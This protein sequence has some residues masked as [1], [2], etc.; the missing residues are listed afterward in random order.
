MALRT[1]NSTVRQALLEND[2]FILAHLIKF[3][4]PQPQEGTPTGVNDF[5]YLTDA[6][7]PLTLDSIEYRPARVMSIGTVKENVEAKA[8]QLSIKLG[9]SDIGTTVTET[10]DVVSGQYIDLK[11]DALKAGFKVGDV[12]KQDATSSGAHANLQLKISSIRSGSIGNERI[13]GTVIS[14]S[15]NSLVTEIGVEYKITT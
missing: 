10:I 3:E 2:E 14:T 8:G 15:P 11:R 7:F 9:A 4:K 12:I 5:V 6:P 13:Y 1:M